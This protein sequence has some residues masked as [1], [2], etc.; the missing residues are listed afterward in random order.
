MSVSSTGFDGSSAMGPVPREIAAV[1]R[2]SAMC[3]NVQCSCAADCQLSRFTSD[4]T[5]PVSPPRVMATTV[6]APAAGAD[7]QPDLTATWATGA[8]GLA[9]GVPAY[10]AR[11][12]SMRW[13]ARIVSADLPV[14]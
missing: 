6:L 12:E 7:D 14:A 11:I 4:G 8:A 9:I 13:R 2:N 10:W 3:W 1:G 5:R